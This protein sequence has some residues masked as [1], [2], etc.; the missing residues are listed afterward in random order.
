MKERFKVLFECLILVA[1]MFMLLLVSSLAFFQGFSFYEHNIYNY[2]RLFLISSLI[3]VILFVAYRFYI[4]KSRSPFTE[5]KSRCS[6]LG[7]L[8]PFVF[9]AFV[10]VVNGTGLLEYSLFGIKPQDNRAISYFINNFGASGFV[11]SILFIAVMPAV[12][13]EFLFRGILQRRLSSVLG[14]FSAVIITSVV[15]ALCHFEVGVFLPIFILSVFLGSVYY[16]WGGIL[17]SILFHF[18]NNLMSVLSI[19]FAAD[20]EIDSWCILLMIP[21]VIIAG[22]FIFYTFFYKKNT[23]VTDQIGEV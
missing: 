23:G 5:I 1:A 4:Y 10:F 18:L 3:I 7:W 20:C 8:L 19:R 13:E 21:G 12:F 14:P 11:L 6:S 15:F 17:G 9:C 2:I 22:I 16:K